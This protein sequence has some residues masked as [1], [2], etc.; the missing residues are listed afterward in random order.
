MAANSHKVAYQALAQAL[1]KLPGE[2]QPTRSQL[3]E[4]G[5]RLAPLVQQAIVGDIGKLTMSGWPEKGEPE[6][7]GIV[8]KAKRATEF[9]TAKT[10]AVMVIRDR[11]GAGMIRL[12]DSGRNRT[13]T[14]GRTRQGWGEV[15]AGPGV[16]RSTGVTARTSSG[17]V[18]K[19]QDARK[20]AKRWNGYTRAE[21]TWEDALKLMRT[22]SPALAAEVV[23]AATAE[24]IRKVVM[25]G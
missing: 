10:G 1:L 8:L 16:N 3:Q 18:R 2:I 19:V 15:Y 24:R 5:D 21:R 11:R 14:K 4:I 25:G 12:L 7:R 17:G 13:N 9:G 6:A 22:A 23:G 20:G